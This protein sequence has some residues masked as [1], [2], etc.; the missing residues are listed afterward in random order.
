MLKQFKQLLTVH[1][2][3]EAGEECEWLPEADG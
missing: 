3:T 2:E 1:S